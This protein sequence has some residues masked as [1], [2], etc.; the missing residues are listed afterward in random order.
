M[1]AA[2]ASALIGVY[3][4]YVSPYKG[5]CC[6]Y[7]VHTKRRSCSTY[8]R[9]IVE[10]LGVMALASALPRQFRRCKAAYLALMAAAALPGSP[11]AAPEHK[12]K[13][14]DRCDCNPCDCGNI[15]NL[16]CDGP[17]DCSF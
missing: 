1:L 6:A 14:W 13:W 9:A 10:R 17:C 7:R 15:G 16:P 4:R 12:R 11:S 8:A 3:Q 2:P 5:F